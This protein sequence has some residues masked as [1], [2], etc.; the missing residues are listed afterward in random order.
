MEKKD[1]Y[2]KLWFTSLLILGFLHFSCERPFMHGLVKVTAVNVLNDQGIEGIVSSV[3]KQSSGDF[4]DNEKQVVVATTDANGECELTYWNTNSVKHHV[5]RYLSSDT[6]NNY[7]LGNVVIDGEDKGNGYDFSLMSHTNADL[8]MEFAPRAYY[9]TRCDNINYYDENDQ[10]QYKWVNLDVKNDDEEGG[11][12]LLQGD[13]HIG[14]GTGG[15]Y[16][17]AGNHYIEWWVTR[18]GVTTHFEDY[19]YVEPWDSTTYYIAY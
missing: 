4:F 1:T 18:D 12:V 2:K 7:F 8:T 5:F 6:L 19:F 9:K 10:L 11:G 14:F 13:A 3:W 15:P 17:G 16:K